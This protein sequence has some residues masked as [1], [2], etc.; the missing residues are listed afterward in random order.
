MKIYLLTILLIFTL[1]FSNEGCSR[2]VTR[3]SMDIPKSSQDADKPRDVSEKK[4][5][6]IVSLELSSGIIGVALSHKEIIY[7][8]SLGGNFDTESKMIGGNDTSGTPVKFQINDVK[9]V[10]HNSRDVYVKF[11]KNRGKF[12][13]ETQII[14]GTTIEG[15]QAEIHTDEIIY[16][17]FRKKYGFWVTF[18]GIGV[19]VVLT[20]I[21]LAS[22]G[23]GPNVDASG[24]LW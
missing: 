8:D 14:T 22:D 5:G 3:T 21:I 11:D 24:T 6:N 10:I 15:N 4:R 17:E 13:A 18:I 12:D 1:I 23:V 16:Y 9:Q 19:P 20:I 7:F 2:I